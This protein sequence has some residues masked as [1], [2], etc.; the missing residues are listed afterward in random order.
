[1]ASSTFTAGGWLFAA[2]A[3]AF[4]VASLAHGNAHVRRIFTSA[5][6]VACVTAAVNFAQAEGVSRYARAGDGA[7]LYW[8]EWAGYAVSLFFIGASVAHFLDPLADMPGRSGGPSAAATAAFDSVYAGLLLSTVGLGG[9]AGLLISSQQRAVQWAFVLLT[10]GVYA[11]WIAYAARNANTQ[12][13]RGRI[14]LLVY[15]VLATLFYVVPYVAG[16]PVYGA[17]SASTEHALYLAGNVLTKL[18]LPLL[19]AWYL[20]APAQ[21]VRGKLRRTPADSSQYE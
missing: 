16:P 4:A 1:M 11:V 18:L 14:A 15:F 12:R 20:W 17:I 10:S 8:L 9:L 21:P 6:A 13:F 5:T 7:D 3:A 19:E 2:A